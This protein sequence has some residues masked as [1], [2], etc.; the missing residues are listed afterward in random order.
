MGLKDRDH[1]QEQIAEIHGVQLAQA[2]LIL[3]I[4]RGTL[5]VESARFRG[6]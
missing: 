2:G 3:R 6:G 5:A 1:M 4:K